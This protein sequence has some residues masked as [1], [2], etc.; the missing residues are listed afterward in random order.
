MNIIGVNHIAAETEPMNYFVSN[1]VFGSQ[2]LRK[3]WDLSLVRSIPSC[4][5][6]RKKK[7]AQTLFQEWITI[8]WMSKEDHQP[9]LFI[10]G[11]FDMLSR[12]KTVYLPGM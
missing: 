2:W 4:S 10:T 6:L 5:A 9:K 11:K 8:V 1:N 7:K 12:W 3:F